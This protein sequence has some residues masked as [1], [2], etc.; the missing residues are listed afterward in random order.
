MDFRPDF[1]DFRLDL[2][3]GFR[4]YSRDFTSDYKDFRDFTLY[5]KVFKADL[6]DFWFDFTKY[7]DRRLCRD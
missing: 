6:R 2:N 3:K 1:R 7:R 5:F 4:P